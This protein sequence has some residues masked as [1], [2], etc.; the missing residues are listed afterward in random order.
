[1]KKIVKNMIMFSVYAAILLISHV[2]AVEYTDEEIPDESFVIGNYLFT[3]T[4]ESKTGWN[5]YMTIK[6]AML[7][8]TS[9]ENQLADDIKIYYKYGL[10][11]WVDYFDD[12]ATSI[13]APDL[14][15]IYYVNGICIDET[16]CGTEYSI[17]FYDSDKSTL[18]YETSASGISI[19]DAKK[20]YTATKDGYY[21][22]WNTNTG[23]STDSSTGYINEDIS[24][25][26]SWSQTAYI[27]TFTSLDNEGHEYTVSTSEYDGNSTKITKPT[28]P[29]RAGYTFSGWC[30]ENSNG[31]CDEKKLITNF[32]SYKKDVTFNAVWSAITYNITYDLK[33]GS[34]TISDGT[35]CNLYLK[36]ASNNATLC[37]ITSTIPTK[38]GY[39]FAGW[40]SSSSANYD[41]DNILK[42]G[43]SGSAIYSILRDNPNITLYAVWKPETYNIKYIL[44][45]GTIDESAASNLTT[46]YTVSS[47]SQTIDLPTV[48]RYG[49]TYTWNTSNS[50]SSITDNYTKLT[51]NANCTKD[52]NLTVNYSDLEVNI[53]YYE[54]DGTTVYKSV[55]DKFG[56]HYTPSYTTNDTNKIFVGWYQKETT[57][58]ASQGIIY[59]ATVSIRNANISDGNVVKL[60]PYLKDKESR[61]ITYTGSGT[62]Y[63]LPDGAI[64]M[65]NSGDSV[66]LPVPTKSGY[67]FLGWCTDG[68][69]T[70]SSPVKTLENQTSNL[71]LNAKWE[72]EKYEVTVKDLSGNPI[73]TG[74]Y[75][76]DKASV[77][78]D[79]STL[80]A[81]SNGLSVGLYHD[82]T[83]LEN[84]SDSSDSYVVNLTINNDIT[85]LAVYGYTYKIISDIISNNGTNVYERGVSSSDTITYEL[86][87]TTN[88][89]GW[90]LRT[91]ND[92]GTYG[93]EE[94]STD[95]SLSY[96]A[97]NADVT[98][99]AMHNTITYVGE[100]GINY[101][102]QFS[103]KT[104]YTAGTSIWLSSVSDI[105]GNG[106]TFSSYVVTKM[107]GSE[108]T[109]TY[110][111]YSNSYV[112]DTSNCF[113]N[114]IVTVKFK[115]SV[116]VYEYISTRMNGKIVTSKID[117]VSVNYGDTYST[118]LSSISDR[119]NNYTNYTV[120]SDSNFKNTIDSSTAIINSHTIY[121]KN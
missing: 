67:K 43:T 85:L 73:A 38:S 23:G 27:A 70:C 14:T 111:N 50:C 102:S 48:S 11:D 108:T 53:I 116:L 79:M 60:Y 57:R 6:F 121:I 72:A 34:G 84:V 16:M 82:G 93:Y 103:G 99:V 90:Y 109:L 28:N 47:S 15:H 56:T 9:L 12:S 65:F 21:L 114:I 39:E 83:L 75:D 51:I 2:Y 66:T 115:Y 18:L 46:T 68:T 105:T 106:G 26:A 5:G 76:N 45:D 19:D 61:T 52:I 74:T 71:T 78:F 88:F 92:D 41:S 63:T 120:Y 113:G 36:D 117:S 30:E 59:E 22:T 7:G 119:W 69:T 3:S 110:D 13:S 98:I 77:V 100:D 107:D 96:Q 25:Y 49:Y 4:A 35:T 54:E 80:T 89:Q 37:T 97:K 8:A 86:K 44:G 87:D 81:N 40:S 24:F 94:I 95:S 101:N 118:V 58:E 64:T 17:K 10:G 29:K 112:L 42:P 32:S 1:M 62:D 91:D 20:L 31:K 104:T 55:N 33:E